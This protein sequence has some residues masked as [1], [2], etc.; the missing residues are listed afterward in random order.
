MGKAR[1]SSHAERVLEK[2][3]RWGRNINIL[4]ALAIGG[5][6]L[7]IPG[8]N[9]ILATWAGVNAVQAGGFELARQHTKQK[10][11]KKTIAKTSH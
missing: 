1:E 5:F 3:S 9:V 10:K 2:L 8:P 7:A 11:A 6:A 4:G